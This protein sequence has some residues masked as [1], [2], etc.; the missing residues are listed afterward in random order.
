MGEEKKAGE[1][2]EEKKENESNEEKSNENIIVIKVDMHCQCEACAKKIFRS[3]KAYQGVEDVA[4][5]RKTNMVVVKGKTAEPM[6]LCDRIR[7]KTGRN[8][9]LLSP[10]PKPQEEQP[11][12]DENKVQKEQQQ[13]EQPPPIVK[14]VLQVY[15]HC[16]ACAQLLRKR[17]RKM[18]GIESVETDVGKSQVI[19]K[20]VIGD[21]ENLVKYVHK[22]T[23]K[24][25]SLV[26]DEEDKKQDTSTS[27][28]QEKK[29]EDKKEAKE[30][31][32][33]D[34]Q[35]P[36][37]NIPIIEDHAKMLMMMGDMNRSYDYYWPSTTPR[38]DHMEYHHDQHPNNLNHQPQIFSD[39]NPNAC[40][41][42]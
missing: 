18:K 7:H 4:V 29:G 16:E 12:E 38:Y 31:N 23:R 28:E 3:L 40:S 9:H 22:R 36:K 6:K 41:V 30:N 27:S 21:P 14:V 24:Q 20:G 11:K 2:V 42:M 33:N 35:V 17:I 34:E 26:K 5:D 1:G 13:K 37:N 39:E 32:N 10:L 25:V 19:V 15:M 8:A